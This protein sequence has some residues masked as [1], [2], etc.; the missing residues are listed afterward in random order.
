MISQCRLKD[1][2][3]AK[4]IEEEW[5]EESQNPEDEDDVSEVQKKGLEGG[6]FGFLNF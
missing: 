3:S 6:Q 1:P 4:E 5:Q 2:R